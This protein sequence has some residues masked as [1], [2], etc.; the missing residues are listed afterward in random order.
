VY[1]VT[2]L[3]KRELEEGF[4]LLL[5]QKPNCMYSPLPEMQYSWWSKGELQIKG[6]IIKNKLD[7]CRNSMYQP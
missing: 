5:R 6:Q 4:M 2:F 1:W 7:V 3:K